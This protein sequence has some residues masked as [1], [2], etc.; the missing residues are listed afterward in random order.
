MVLTIPVWFGSCKN[1]D[2][3]G[4][5]T[6][7]AIE[8]S[9]K[10]SGYKIDPAVDRF[11]TGQKSNDLLAAYKQALPNGTNIVDCFTSKVLTLSNDG[12][13]TTTA[14]SKCTVQTDIFPIANNSTWKADGNK[15]TVTNG[16]NVTTYD[17]SISGNNLKM[18]YPA[19]QDFDG[20][21]KQETY[22]YTI[23]LT[24]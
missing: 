22:T 6:T 7:P 3:P 11:E 5:P 10:V 14:G 12:K 16:N 15:V 18:S 8:G 24:K 17:T 20:D 2:D 23:E 9:W 13:L 1:D 21:G 4:T 19:S